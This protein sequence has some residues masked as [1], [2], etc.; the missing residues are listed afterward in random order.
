MLDE[1]KTEGES[2]WLFASGRKLKDGSGGNARMKNIGKVWQEIR[3]DAGL[4]H[5]RL[6]DLR[7][8][9]AS[10]LINSGHSLYVVQQVLGHSDPSV[11]TRYSHLSQE[12]LHESANRVDSDVDK[13]LEVSAD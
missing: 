1:L 11:T 8:M 4:E 13:A 6:H 5:I 2:E 12:T 3:K 9:N 7:H 10:M